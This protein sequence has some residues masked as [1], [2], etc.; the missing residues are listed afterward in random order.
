VI[1]G[2]L[3]KIVRKRDR[4]VSGLFVALG[5]GTGSL[6][7]FMPCTAIVATHGTNEFREHLAESLM[8]QGGE[9]KTV[10]IK[11]LSAKAGE[12]PVVG[13]ALALQRDKVKD[14]AAIEKLVTIGET[15]TGV[16]R[17]ITEYGAFVDIGGISG[18]LHKT[19]IVGENLKQLFTG[20]FVE[21]TVIKKEGGRVGLS[22]KRLQQKKFFDNLH[23]DDI[24]EGVVRNTVDFGGFV[25]LD[26]ELRMDGLLHWRE[27]DGVKRPVIGDIVRVRVISFNAEAG[28]ISLSLRNVPRA[29]SE[30]TLV[31]GNSQS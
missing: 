27:C 4:S 7:A 8:K 3:K 14:P 17:N 21:V 9:D 16:V 30:A 15:Y 22:L 10:R 20:K 25:T 2:K 26:S 23:V 24:I 18:L 6:D 28:R 29:S 1:T 5:E 19:E 11:V 31:G 13:H 12:R